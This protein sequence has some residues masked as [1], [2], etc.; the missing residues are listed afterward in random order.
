MCAFIFCVVIGIVLLVAVIVFVLDVIFENL[1]NFGVERL[2]A[3]VTS[4]S[5]ETT[6]VVDN[7][8][9]TELVDEATEDTTSEVTDEGEAEQVVETEEE[10]TTEEQ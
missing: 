4:S 2:K 1:N 3:I 9:E 6:D 8:V 7:S 5:E 10:T